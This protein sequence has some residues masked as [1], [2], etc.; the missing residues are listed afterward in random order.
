MSP[1]GL[2]VAR[3]PSITVHV[4][5]DE[6]PNAMDPEKRKRILYPP[7]PRHVRRAVRAGTMK[8]VDDRDRITVS[9]LVMADSVLTAATMES[10]S[11]AVLS[12]VPAA[13]AEESMRRAGQALEGLARD[14]FK[15]PRRVIARHELRGARIDRLCADILEKEEKADE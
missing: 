10:L 5:G 3:A 11:N 7:P 9:I 2:L 4:A 13:T 1:R 12:C 6:P 14:G 15:I 8:W